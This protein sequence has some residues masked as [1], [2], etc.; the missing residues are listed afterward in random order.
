LNIADPKSESELPPAGIAIRARGLH[1]R[2]GSVR[3]LNGLDLDAAKSA[4]TV[5]LGPNGAGKT[6]L[7][8]I[9]AGL[10]RPDSGQA[11]LG[12]I[13]IDRFPRAARAR[14]GL[15]G[16]RPLIYP[17]LSAEENLRFHAQL[18][19]CPE[20]SIRPALETAGL[21]RHRHRPARGFSRGMRQS[22]A[23]ARATLHEP[24]VLLLD[25][26][27]SG[28]DP[29]AADRL[30]LRL[31][32]LADRGCAVLM[33]SHD[34]ERA[35]SLADQLL[36]M[37]AGR[38][39]WRG[40]AAG[41]DAAS[42]RRLYLRSTELGAQPVTEPGAQPVT[43]DVAIATRD[44]DSLSPEVPASRVGSKAVEL[45][46]P[47]S[48]PHRVEAPSDAGPSASPDFARPRPKAPGLLAAAAILAA[49]DLRVE[50]RGREILPPVL[51]FALLVTVIFQFALPREPETGMLVGAAG[52]LWSA[53]LFGST[54]GLSR[55]LGAEMDQGGMLGLMVAPI[56]RGAIFVGKWLSGYALSLVLAAGLL[57][58]GLVWL[59][60]PASRMV[61]LAGIVA[62]GL[63]G[64]VA[65]G[66]LVAAM[67]VASRA[68]EVLLPVLLFPLV[69]P[70]ILPAVEASAL[71]LAP[72]VG[73]GPNLVPHLALI[74]AFDV[75][76][77][78]LGFLLLPFV[79]E[80]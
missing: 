42:L 3:A 17:E 69:L 77:L 28:L 61:G 54:L 80:A 71:L 75:I 67:A 79:A 23:I 76:F 39:I 1:R 73:D 66:T 68:R 36:I 65:A 29:A 52:A 9:L 72:R 18:Y 74:A 16:H 31:R 60:I 20:A 53:L 70:L 63:V 40:S 26:P 58:A 48:R 49:K 45:P 35:G 27:F 21:L 78:V 62:L 64:W 32:A 5:L 14:L 22:L 47:A 51:V 55:A 50:L 24:E 15:V 8:S 10:A 37:S 4:I 11:W 43:V 44:A 57:P 34:L 59:G 2:F 25:E 41:L 19:G 38:V 12:G 13:A 6:T 33:T 46:Q 30:A 56:D 7:L